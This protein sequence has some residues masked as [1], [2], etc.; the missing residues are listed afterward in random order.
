MGCDELHFELGAF[1][2]T[3]MM[4]VGFWV[5]RPKPIDV[6]LP[7][8]PRQHAHE[9]LVEETS[10]GTSVGYLDGVHLSLAVND[11]IGDIHDGKGKLVVHP[12]P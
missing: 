2:K 12:D 8:E 10:A 7:Q 4:D 6:I 1:E 9:L 11:A 3:S 5:S